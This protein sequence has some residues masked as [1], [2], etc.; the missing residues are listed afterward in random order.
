MVP[1][2]LIAAE[3]LLQM[4][5]AM[6]NLTIVLDRD[7]EDSREI[8]ATIADFYRQSLWMIRL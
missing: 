4:E 1:V 2:A 6:R 5:K 8:D 7:I 3:N